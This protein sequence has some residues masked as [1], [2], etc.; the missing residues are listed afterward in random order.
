MSASPLQ[1]HLVPKPPGAGRRSRT[2][3]TVQFY[4][5]DESLIH[6]LAGFVGGALVSGDSALVV[7]TPAHRQQ[8]QARLM[9]SGFDV[10]A[11]AG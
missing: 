9:S 2:S 8:L 6:A 7:A 4:T 3:H 11:A 5:D 10:E 1:P